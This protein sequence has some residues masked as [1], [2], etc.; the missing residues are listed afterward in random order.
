MSGVVCVC[1]YVGFLALASPLA[2]GKAL[3]ESRSELVIFAIV[4]VFFGLVMGHSW[5]AASRDAETSE[6][7]AA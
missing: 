6:S 2:F 5:F 3:I 1:A 4:S 7:A